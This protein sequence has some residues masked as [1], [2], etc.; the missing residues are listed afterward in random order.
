MLRISSAEPPGRRKAYSNGR[1]TCPPLSQLALK[2][3]SSCIAMASSKWRSRS[4]PEDQCFKT[5]KLLCVWSLGQQAS[6]VASV[7]RLGDNCAAST[8]SALKAQAQK[9]PGSAFCSEGV[10]ARALIV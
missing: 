6:T 7:Q 3:S 10:Q 9:E 1:G 4:E 5:R 2:K 8:R